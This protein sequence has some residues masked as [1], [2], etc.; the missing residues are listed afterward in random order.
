MAKKI[1]AKTKDLM[2]KLVFW[3]EGAWEAEIDEVSSISTKK[4]LIRKKLLTGDT[5]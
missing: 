4:D 2:A 1:S 3:P 5:L